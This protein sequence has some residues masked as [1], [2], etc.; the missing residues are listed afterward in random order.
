MSNGYEEDDRDRRGVVPIVWWLGGLALAASAITF[1]LLYFNKKGDLGD[2]Q[3]LFNETTNTL[4]QERDSLN[5]QLQRAN[6]N[7]Q[8]LLADREKIAQDLA[9][10]QAR[11]SRLASA[12][13]TLTKQ[14]QLTR[15]SLLA[16]LADAQQL[17]SQNDGLQRDLV[18]V[19]GEVAGLKSEL[20]AK[21]GALA[22]KQAVID[23]KN[24]RI[25]ADSAAS[26]ALKDSVRSEQVQGF[27][28]ITELNGAYGIATI[29]VPYSR[30]FYGLSTVNGYVISKHWLTGVGLGLYNFNGGLVLPLYLDFRY[31][32]RER[33]IT[34][35]IF[36][37]GGYMLKLED[38]VN[39]STFVNPGFGIYAK[40]GR[41]TALNLGAGIFT[42]D[43]ER[44][45][46]FVNVKLGLH[47]YGKTKAEKLS[48]L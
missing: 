44:R 2:L 30:Y 41:K 3:L 6:S 4:T 15:D 42:H 24:S 20:A 38:M 32:F 46:S 35:Y 25:A 10:Q 47:F 23:T 45:S 37:D 17:R 21:D 9:T 19:R 27:V 28:N 18:T 12:N 5:G 33:K 16:A 22:D 26:A 34:P 7:Y 48:G 14:Q 13:N 29:S 8:V 31:S 11:N 40:L 43:L 39:S 36:A 1:A